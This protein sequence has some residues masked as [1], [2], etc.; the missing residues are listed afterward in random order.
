MFIG[1]LESN[2][3]LALYAEKL[4]Y[5]GNN[6]KIEASKIGIFS[7]NIW[8][9]QWSNVSAD[10]MGCQS[11]Q[12]IGRGIYDVSKGSEYGCGG[13]GGSYGGFGGIGIS[14]DTE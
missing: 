1:I 10:G 2:Y 7:R 13:S 3:T 5:L 12:G 4:I 11:D 14:P 8:I 9:D 6:G